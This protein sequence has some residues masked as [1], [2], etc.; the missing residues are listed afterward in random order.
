MLQCSGAVHTSPNFVCA[1]NLVVL[2]VVHHD[3]H[4]RR[5]RFNV[6]DMGIVSERFQ[7]IHANVSE[8][9]RASVLQGNVC[10]SPPHMHCS[11]WQ[12]NYLISFYH[13]TLLPT[14]GDGP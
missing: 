10:A 11:A 9:H 5:M 4:H 2:S 8:M 7:N 3:D 13:S 1:Y 12:G 14:F 6:I